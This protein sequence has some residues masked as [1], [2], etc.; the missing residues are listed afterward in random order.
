MASL[1]LSGETS[2]SVTLSA[3]E[4]AGSNTQT[5]V[6]T[7]GTLAPIVSGTAVTASGASVTFTSIPSW[8]KRITVA[9][10]GL[11]FAGASGQARV[12]IGTGGSLTASGYTSD[13][14]VVTGSNTCNTSSFTN[15]LALF[16]GN[17]AGDTLWGVT[18]ITQ[19]SGN[20]WVS[21]FTS[22]R[23][24]GAASRAGTGYIT[25]GGALDIVGVV[26]TTGS[27]DAG[28]INILYE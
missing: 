1:V 19:L 9:I 13:S 6:A 8:V 16:N 7:T 15:G 12:Q 11:S 14:L 3:P 22:C 2:G 17:V 25:L 23:S 27:F 5:L 4:I 18:T 10:Q 20:L 26:A 28:T 21:S 24:D